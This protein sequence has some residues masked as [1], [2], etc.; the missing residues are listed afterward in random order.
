MTGWPP[1]TES[2]EK[3]WLKGNP[4]HEITISQAGIELESEENKQ[5]RERELHRATIARPDIW[6]GIS[7]AHKLMKQKGKAANF[8]RVV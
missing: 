2:A 5:H 3:R 7:Q 1:E 6:N 8:G 4:G